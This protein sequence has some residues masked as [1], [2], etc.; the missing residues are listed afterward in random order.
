MRPKIFHRKR[1][2][3][4]TIIV[5]LI[6]GGKIILA[7]DSQTTAGSAKRT[8]SSKISGLHLAGK[9]ILIAES[10]DCTLSAKAVEN[11]ARELAVCQFDDWRRPADALQDAV[12][13]TKEE[14]VRLNNWENN[15]DLGEQYLLENP[16]SLM[17]AYFDGETPYLYVVNSVPGF[18]ARQKNFAA[19]GCGGT[20]GEFILSRA[21]LDKMT[22]VE[23]LIAAIY[24]VEEVKRVDTYCGGP[25]KAAVLGREKVL[26][27]E[28]DTKQVI[29]SAVEALNGYEDE[30]RKKWNALLQDVITRT[31]EIYKRK[32]KPPDSPDIP[33]P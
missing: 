27:S 13:K 32:Q 24:T 2:T 18:A 25:T 22:H 20:V 30:L 4:V 8:D 9:P 11:F 26:F 12:R 16:F 21:E 29:A 6:C 3:R 31:N 1:E 15:R 7:C 28:N 17:L 14:L 5:G 23:G 33:N 10:G 19:I